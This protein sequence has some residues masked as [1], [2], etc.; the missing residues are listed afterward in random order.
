MQAYSQI[1]SLPDPEAS[2]PFYGIK[3]GSLIEHISETRVSHQIPDFK[4]RKRDSHKV[5]E[6][7]VLDYRNLDLPIRFLK[8][9]G[10]SYEAIYVENGAISLGTSNSS[11]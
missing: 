9:H 5:L 1:M 11:D 10:E 6:I 3:S 8:G 4:L 7:Q 2:N